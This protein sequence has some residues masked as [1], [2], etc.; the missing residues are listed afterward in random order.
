MSPIAL[1]SC[2]VSRKQ[3]DTTARI[4]LSGQVTGFALE[5]RQPFNIPV[6]RIQVEM[7][8]RAQIESFMLQLAMIVS[9][10]ALSAPVAGMPTVVDAQDVLETMTLFRLRLEELEDGEEHFV[11]TLELAE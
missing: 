1:A 11:L 8:G 10:D 5:I 3:L 6:D 7:Q 9:G 2:P 4:F